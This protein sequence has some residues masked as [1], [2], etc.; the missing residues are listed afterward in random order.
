MQ[1]TYTTPLHY[2]EGRSHAKELT[3]LI[4][5]V[6]ITYM[7]SSRNSLIQILFEICSSDKSK[8]FTIKSVEDLLELLE[9]ASELASNET[10]K[11]IVRLLAGSPKTARELEEN[12]K[13][14]NS[15]VYRALKSLEASGLIECSE[16]LTSKSGKKVRTCYTTVKGIVVLHIAESLQRTYY[17]EPT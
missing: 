2:F 1:N 5:L 12:L 9:S 3:K 14:H 16:V 7:L 11:R 15:T 6:N 4:L 17:S 13:V 10:K 8:C